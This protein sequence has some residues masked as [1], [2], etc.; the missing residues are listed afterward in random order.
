MKTRCWCRSVVCL[1]V[2]LTAYGATAAAQVPVSS[3]YVEVAGE[4]VTVRAEAVS[5]REVL[6]ELARQSSLKLV[7]LT[8]LDV[9]VSVK[10]ERRLLPDAIKSILHGQ[11]F[12]LQYARVLPEHE[13]AGQVRPN[14]LWV[15]P[16]TVADRRDEPEEVA[17]TLVPEPENVIVTAAHSLSDEDLKV[18]LQAVLML[19]VVEDERSALALAPAL[20]DTDAV[21]REEAAEALG[22]IGGRDALELLEYALMDLDKDVRETA[23]EAFAEIGG[24]E[25]AQALAPALKDADARV[26]TD[27]VDA[28]GE[29]GGATAT[30]LLRQALADEEPDIREIAA[31]YL[32]TLPSRGP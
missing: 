16:G 31:G 10:F 26:R 4:A 20:L 21:I 23:I 5:I 8:P 32:A 28:L 13:R 27:A 11:N 24:D 1:A 22:G 18:R 25:A 12:A 3:L 19:A 9:P 29:I 17:G 2:V 7:L 15:L 6:D 14:T 30:N